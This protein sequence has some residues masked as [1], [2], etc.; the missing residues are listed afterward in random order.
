MGRADTSNGYGTTKPSLEFHA[1]HEAGCE[2]DMTEYEFTI[3]PYAAPDREAVVALWRLVFT[4]DRPWNEPSDVIARK[5]SVQADLFLVGVLGE[6]VAGTV[7]AGFDGVRGWVHHLA[8]LPELQ[9]KGFASLLMDRAEEGLIELGCP[10]LNLQ[11][12][13]SNAEVIAFYES[14]GHSV[15]DVISLGK[16]LGPWRRDPV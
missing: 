7:L 5:R 9:R 2:M 4:D 10:K 8:V 6:Q 15:E 13:G 3:R 11:V 14:R 16:P 1:F 12:R